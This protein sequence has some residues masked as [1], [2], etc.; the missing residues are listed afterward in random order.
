MSLTLALKSKANPAKAKIL[1]SFFKTQKGE[2]GE[3]D[4]FLGVPVPEIRKIAKQYTKLPIKQIKVH[5]SSKFHEERLAAL[6]I[7]VNNYQKSKDKEIFSP[8]RED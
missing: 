1:Q 7:L 8:S 2:Y 6:L 4:I 5:L 3:G